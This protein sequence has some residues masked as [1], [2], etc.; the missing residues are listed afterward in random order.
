MRMRHLLFGGF[1]DGY[2]ST[3]GGARWTNLT[4]SLDADDRFVPHLSTTHIDQHSFAFAPHD[5]RTIY[6]GNDGG[7]FKSTDGAR[8]SP[9]LG[10]EPMH[11]KRLTPN[12]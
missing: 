9:E 10:R 2:K 8:V 4:K 5:A 12:A 11:P 6:L 7:I 1:R 3:N